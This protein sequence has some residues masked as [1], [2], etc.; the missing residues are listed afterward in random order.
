MSADLVKGKSQDG[1]WLRGPKYSP[2]IST[3]VLS[4]CGITDD[5][6]NT[7]AKEYASEH[8][9]IVKDPVVFIQDYWYE[10]TNMGDLMYF[11]NS[12][13]SSFSRS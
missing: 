10:N 2:C 13:S 12:V 4:S 1:M 7:L 9:R 5:L 6:A 8:D 11:Y 3:T